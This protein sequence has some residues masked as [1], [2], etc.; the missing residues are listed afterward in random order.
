MGSVS[1]ATFVSTHDPSERWLLYGVRLSTDGDTG[2][3]EWTKNRTP[4][5]LPYRATELRS[6]SSSNSLLD[7]RNT[8]TGAGASLSARSSRS[9]RRKWL[10]GTLFSAT[11]DSAH[12]TEHETLQSCSSSPFQIPIK[13]TGGFCHLQGRVGLPT[14]ACR[15]PACLTTRWMPTTT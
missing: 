5:Q 3:P 1:I 7:A 8:S 15:T 12:M 9:S 6:C 10:P 14:R 2:A 4:S 11:R 13:F